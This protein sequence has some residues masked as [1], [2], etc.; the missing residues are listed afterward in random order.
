MSSRIITG[1][2]YGPLLT[3]IVADLR[4]SP[5]NSNR[6]TIT[7]GC[8]GMLVCFMYRLSTPSP[9]DATLIPQSFVGSSLNVDGNP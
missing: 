5:T 9:D 2:S 8:T 3:F 6:L 1:Y 7:P 4:S